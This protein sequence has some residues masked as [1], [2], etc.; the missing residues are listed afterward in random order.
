MK[1]RNRV[2]TYRRHF[3]R[4][5]GWVAMDL[6]RMPWELASAAVFEEKKVASVRAMVSGL[7]DGLSHDLALPPSLPK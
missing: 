2:R 3:A 7:W 1:M 6:W 4:F 5:P